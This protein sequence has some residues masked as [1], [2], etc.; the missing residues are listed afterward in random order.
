MASLATERI[1]LITLSSLSLIFIVFPGAAN[2]A[3]N[4]PAPFNCVK[5]P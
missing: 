1:W 2:N 5:H 3:D 4:L